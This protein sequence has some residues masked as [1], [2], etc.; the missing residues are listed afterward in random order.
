MI[1]IHADWAVAD[2]VGFQDALRKAAKIAE[3]HHALV[4]V[5]VVPSR[6]E[7]GFGHIQPGKELGDGARR[8]V[9]FVEK[10]DRQRAEEMTRDGYLWN[11]GIFAWRVGDFLDD[12]RK[13]T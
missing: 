6:P 11:S 13:L 9:Q 7:T 8:V 10:P 4:T 12:V 1:S 3:A 2:A 5:G